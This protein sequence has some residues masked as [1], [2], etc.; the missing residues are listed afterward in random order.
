MTKAWE[1]VAYTN[2]GEFYCDACG[3][4]EWSPVFADSMIEFEGYAC[5]TCGCVLVDTEWT[6]QK[7]AMEYRWLICEGCG[8]QVPE[9]GLNPLG[10]KCRNC[11]GKFER[12]KR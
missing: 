2:E 10:G 8:S 1:V 9:T 7:D 12:R 6:L 5:G 3:K 4:K 11:G